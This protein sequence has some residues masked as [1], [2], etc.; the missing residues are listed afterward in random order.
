MPVSN[1]DEFKIAEGMLIGLLLVYPCTYC[2]PGMR[3]EWA[4]THAR[5][6]RQKEEVLLLTEEMRHVVAYLDWKASWWPFPPLF[7]LFLSA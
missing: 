5:A 1:G 6:N 2:C 7:L 4:K 3:V